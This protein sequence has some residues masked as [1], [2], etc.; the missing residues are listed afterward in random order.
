VGA[1]AGEADPNN[2][3]SSD[4]R[5]KQRASLLAAAAAEEEEG[6][7]EEEKIEL[8]C[9][10]P[11]PHMLVLLTTANCDA[12]TGKPDATVRACVCS[13]ASV[14]ECSYADVWA[15]ACVET[16]QRA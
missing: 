6:G 13:C 15:W 14:H 10:E 3:K 2:R 9:L 16:D 8:T 1:A 11:S 12:G 5:G 7:E 4:T